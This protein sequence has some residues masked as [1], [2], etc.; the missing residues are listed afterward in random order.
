MW[1]KLTMRIEVR[2]AIELGI[3]VGLAVAVVAAVVAAVAAAAY[4]ATTVRM[5]EIGV[6]IDYSGLN[7]VVVA[8]R[9]IQ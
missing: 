1:T 2:N 5:M 4:L 6:K 8:V 9:Q 7:Q 3:V